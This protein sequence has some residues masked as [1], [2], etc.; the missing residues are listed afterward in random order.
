V[1]AVSFPG[2]DIKSYRVLQFTPGSEEK[3]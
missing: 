3:N 1:R 2:K